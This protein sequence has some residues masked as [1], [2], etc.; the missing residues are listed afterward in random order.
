LCG[1]R[2]NLELGVEIPLVASRGCS[3][4]GKPLSGRREFLGSFVLAFKNK[5]GKGGS[6]LGNYL[7]G[8]RVTS[9]Q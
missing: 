7:L 4:P 3:E 1:R 9:D 8:A 6:F 2:P 5:G